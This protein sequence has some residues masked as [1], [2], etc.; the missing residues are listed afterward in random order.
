MPERYVRG[1]N[2]VGMVRASAGRVIN[3]EQCIGSG[4]EGLV[5]PAS[6]RPHFGIP[7]REGGYIPGRRSLYKLFEDMTQ[8]SPLEILLRAL[9]NGLV[10]RQELDSTTVA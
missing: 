9:V 3:V 8:P 6:G 1:C 7:G 2:D 5:R 10:L 4:S